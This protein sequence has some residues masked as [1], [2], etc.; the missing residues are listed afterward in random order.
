MP[1]V[2]VVGL[3]AVWTLLAGTPIAA[4]MPGNASVPIYLD[5]AH[6]RLFG[7]LTEGASTRLPAGMAVH[8]RRRVPCPAIG[9]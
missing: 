9:C 1:I 7:H 4:G 6:S 5:P 8:Y 2:V 3:S